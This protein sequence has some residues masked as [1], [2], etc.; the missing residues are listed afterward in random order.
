MTIKVN[1]LN[2]IHTQE[3]SQMALADQIYALIDKRFFM[4]VH[5]K[6]ALITQ[7]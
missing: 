5:V 2:V 6:P 3:L 1:A 7:L 4:M